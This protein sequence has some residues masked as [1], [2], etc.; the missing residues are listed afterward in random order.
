MKKG[1]INSL[2]LLNK[3]ETNIVFPVK[4]KKNRKL[5]SSNDTRVKGCARVEDITIYCG[6]VV[7]LYLSLSFSS[8]RF[9]LHENCAL[10]DKSRA[11][12]GYRGVYA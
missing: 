10:R 7:T 1:E 3:R 4:Q 6:A 12:A 5:D 11:R 9:I 8:N 2:L